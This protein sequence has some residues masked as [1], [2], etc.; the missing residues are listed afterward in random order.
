MTISTSY[1]LYI[2]NPVVG[3][4][5]Y[6]A[7]FGGNVGINTSNPPYALDIVG[8]TRIK[9]NSGSQ[10]TLTNSL[11]T[12]TPTNIIFTNDVRAGS[13]AWTVG[14]TSSATS[15]FA[16]APSSNTKPTSDMPY[17]R[18]KLQS[19]A[20]LQQLGFIIYIQYLDGSTNRLV[21]PPGTRFVMKVGFFKKN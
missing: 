12:T 20:P 18:Y 1:G 21:I 14:L 3:T 16:I 4:S 5:R 6:A 13:E 11:S 19:D 10:L 7:Y 17:R 8:T 2:S 9:G 15:V